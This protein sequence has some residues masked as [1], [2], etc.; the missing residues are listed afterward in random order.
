MNELNNTSSE[1]I[2][3]DKLDPLQ[4]KSVPQNNI[5]EGNPE[6]LDKSKDKAPG[7]SS[8]EATKKLSKSKFFDKEE[9]FSPVIN[10]NSVPTPAGSKTEAFAKG[11]SAND[12][13]IGTPVPQS[14]QESAPPPSN[15]TSAHEKVQLAMQQGKK[16]GNRSMKQEEE[17]K[18]SEEVISMKP[19]SNAEKKRSKT[20]MAQPEMNSAPVASPDADVTA[21]QGAEAIV[22]DSIATGTTP[23]TAHFAMEKYEKKNYSG[24][25]EEF[26]KILAKDP[27]NYNALFYSSVS[28]LS[29]GQTDKAI[30]NLNKIL[31][32]KDGEFY[33][34]AQ[35][36]LSLAYIKKKD[37]L[38]AR[39]V[40]ME[41]QKNF[42]SK[43]QK[44]A[45]ET[46]KKMNK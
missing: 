43:Y 14:P 46:L 33:D 38:N 44:Q 32:K 40:L 15:S 34:A 41:V 24:A 28:Y 12:K 11:A 23:N 37:S 36:Y 25:I 22:S 39:K 6:M 29:T 9:H 5:P 42:K 18:L 7:V 1:K 19:E 20:K 16:N 26:E 4:T 17:G 31:E 27:D 21:E 10:V 45:D 13:V 2:F 3:A 30:T 35:W 8:A